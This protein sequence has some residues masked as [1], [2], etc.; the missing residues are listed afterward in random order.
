[1]FCTQIFHIFSSDFDVIN[2]GTLTFTAMLISS[3][4]TSFSGLFTGIFQGLGKE[5]E[6]TIMSVAKGLILIPVM[7]TGKIFW[8]LRGVIWSLT[9]SEILASLI[10]LLMWIYLKKDLLYETF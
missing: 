6:A 7:I 5:K 3:L 4:F 10:G 1:M 2:I 8:G 9:V